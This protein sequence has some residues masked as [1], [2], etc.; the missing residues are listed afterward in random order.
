ME[1]DIERKWEGER[2]KKKKIFFK[3]NS[4]STNLQMQLPVQKR[5]GASKIKCK[6]GFTTT[7]KIS[8]C[9]HE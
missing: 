1:R 4:G 5:T 7:K 8:N 2:D 9:K 3:L 6:K